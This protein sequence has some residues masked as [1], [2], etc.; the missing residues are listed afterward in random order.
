MASSPRRTL[1]SVSEHGV[2]MWGPP[3][4]GKTTFLASLGV[5]LNRDPGAGWRIHGADEASE[6]R[7]IQMTSELVTGRSFPRATQGIEE[8]SWVLSG[9]AP[10]V[11]S[12]LFRRAVREDIRMRLDIIDAQ[13]E[14]AG[15]GM[16]YSQRGEFIE[17]LVRSRG[18]VYLFDPVRESEDGDAFDH[19]FGLLVQLAR[20]V[21]EESTRRDGRLPHH[22]AICVTKF[23]EVPVLRTAE[24]LGLVVPSDDR[25]GFP[26]VPDYEA[27][28]FFARLCSVSGTGNAEMVVS[29]LEQYFDP[30]RIRY[31]VTSAIGFHL[32]SEGKFD[33]ADPTNLLPMEEIDP[34]SGL[35]RTRIRGA[36]HPIN[37]IEPVFWLINQILKESNGGS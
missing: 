28:E 13:G 10:H 7:L 27:R 24:K 5:A 8:Y 26:R 2:A 22:V 18:L 21:D 12:R 11:R 4:S 33:P 36:V 17:G 31:F 14:I 16:D 30:R 35:M 25:Y 9:P 3:G 19:T 34:R 15:Q 1:A 29:A 6:R 20:R 23:D 37:V 32:P